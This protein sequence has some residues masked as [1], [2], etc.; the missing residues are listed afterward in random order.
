DY[1]TAFGFGNVTG[2]DFTGEAL[3]MLVPQSL[4]RDC[5]LARI[6]FGQTVAV[7][8][9]QLACAVAASVNGGYYYLPRLL[10]SVVSSNGKV[11]S[12]N[13]VL[14]NRPIS[15]EASA[16]LATMLEGV[17][18]EG[19]GSKAFIEGYKVGGKTGTAQKYEDGHVAVGKYI[20]SFCGFFPADN[21]QYLALVIV[22]EPE[23][24]YYGSAVAAPVANEIF[25][26]IINIKN[27]QP[28]V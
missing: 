17:V 7:T 28:Y 1:L 15:T 9:I 27:I 14:L 25:T 5:D 24:V 4:L 6:G 13:P 19:S 26:D 18:S 16:I 21:P 23:G 11:E 12:V 10:K 8:G 3:G 2:L 20:S 22:D